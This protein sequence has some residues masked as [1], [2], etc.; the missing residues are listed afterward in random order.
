MKQYLD[1]L[2]KFQIFNSLNSNEI[3]LFHENMELKI[4]SSNSTIVNEGDDGES[5]LFLL[6]GEVIIT[7]ALTLLTSQSNVDNREKTMDKVSGEV[8]FGEMSMFSKNDKRTA[9]ISAKENCEI[10]FLDQE[11]FWKVCEKNPNI[12]FI[13]MK[14]I[15]KLLVNNLNRTNN[16]VLKLTTA[17][18]LMLD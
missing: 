9:T 18:G 6:S 1:K 11:K 8:S 15:G 4:F 17:L 12:G 10:G 16:Q 14:N 3:K 2:N 5:L 13:V 7:K